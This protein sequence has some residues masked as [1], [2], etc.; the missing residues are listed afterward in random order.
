MKE[1]LY[2]W[3]RQNLQKWLLVLAKDLASLF[4]FFVISVAICSGL[5]YI[6]KAF[7]FTYLSTPT[8]ERF[9]TLFGSRADAIKNVLN[10]SPF[11]LSLDISL[12]A[13][14]VCLVGAV[15]GRLFFLTRYLYEYRGL[16]GRALFW[17]VPCA[18]LTAYITSVSYDLDWI[19][20]LVL[21]A[22]CILLL[23]NPCI[24]LVSGL[25]PES[26]AIWVSIS[27]LMQKE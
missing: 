1:A 26:K 15:V 24:R 14:E 8:G 22:L 25:V 21:S 19:P 17:G 2:R 6:L 11:F 3:L 20:A 7:W 27:S 16:R 9:I 4:M 13:L 10:Q 23:L 5:L 18:G 12:V